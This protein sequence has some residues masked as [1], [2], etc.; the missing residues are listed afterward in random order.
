MATA[1]PGQRRVDAL[2]KP[3]ALEVNRT[4]CRNHILPWF[5]GHSITDIAVHAV[6]RRFASMHNTPVSADR[7]APILPVIMRRAEI[8]GRRPEGAAL[9]VAPRRPPASRGPRARE[10]TMWR[11]RASASTHTVGRGAA[12]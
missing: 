11:H 7:S 4:Y 1:R 2:W 8:Y 3:S 12:P 5:E 9:R 10:R 6:R